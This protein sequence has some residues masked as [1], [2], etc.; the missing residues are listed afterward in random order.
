MLYDLREFLDPALD[1]C[2]RLY[3][4]SVV[5]YLI[6]DKAGPHYLDAAE[7]HRQIAARYTRRFIEKGKERPDCDPYGL[8]HL[9]AHVFEAGQTTPP[10]HTLHLFRRPGS[11]PLDVTPI[12]RSLSPTSAVRCSWALTPV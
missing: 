7:Y 12:L 3:H 5:D 9:P 4:E 1:R 10:T 6:G 8:R 11:A 2:Y